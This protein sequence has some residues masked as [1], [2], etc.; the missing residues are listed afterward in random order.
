[1]GAI[2]TAE[3]PR[4]Q[5]SPVPVPGQSQFTLQQNFVPQQPQ[6]VAPAPVQPQ[7]FVPQPQPQQQ[8]VFAQQPQQPAQPQRVQPFV[9]F[10]NQQFQ[11]LTPQQ[12]QQPQA[13][14]AANRF[15]PQAAAPQ[16]QAAGSFN[17]LNPSNFQAFD[18]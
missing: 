11:S 4:S 2:Q 9:A 5:A 18:A 12:P 7:Q 6:Q 3:V 13:A 10:N 8:T 16:P 14:P 15:Q 1:M 17:L